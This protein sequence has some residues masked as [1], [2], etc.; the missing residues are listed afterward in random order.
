VPVPS[1]DT[2]RTRQRYSPVGR[3]TGT[4]QRAIGEVPSSLRATSMLSS[5]STWIWYDDAPTIGV[6]VSST[7]L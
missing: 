7:F 5:S 6:Q 3:V 4:V 1:A 2:A